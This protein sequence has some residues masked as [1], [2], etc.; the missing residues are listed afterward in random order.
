MP[1]P[2]QP[3]VADDAPSLA[4]RAY[5]RLCEAIV[6][7][8]LPPGRK[9]SE[10][11]LAAALAISAQ[12]I[13]EALRRLEG[14]G[15]VESRPRSGTFVAALDESRLLEMGLIRA[16]MEGVAAGL[17]ARGAAPEDLAALRDRMEAISAAT[18][19]N[20]PERLQEANEAFHGTLHAITGNA[21]LI[22]TLR[23]LRAYHVMSRGRVLA[24]PAERKLAEAEHAA[25]LGRIEAGAAEEAEALM[26]AH[27]MRSLS[28]AFPGAFPGTGRDGA[29]PMETMR[30]G[31]HDGPDPGRRAGG[32][33]RAASGRRTCAA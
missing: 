10:R 31:E 8:T 12:P 20:D 21:L 24:N 17:V 19:A 2:L 3:L 13:R 15:L 27:T 28:V 26:R 18:A 22:R 7:G 33:A 32:A 25:I 9:L 11:S 6:D 5:E 23:A 4:E 1:H 14:E 16:S 29:R 30:D